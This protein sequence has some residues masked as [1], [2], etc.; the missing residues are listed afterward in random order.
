MKITRY[1]LSADHVPVDFFA[2]PDGAWEFNDLVEAAGFDPES[3]G[4]CLG[5]LIEP[6]H[7]HPEGSAVVTEM[8]R[9]RPYVAI[10]ECGSMPAPQRLP[11]RGYASSGHA[12]NPGRAA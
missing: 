9:Q 2:D 6:F 7:G 11:E 10:V 3:P 1:T 8:G 4:I 5:A 12:A